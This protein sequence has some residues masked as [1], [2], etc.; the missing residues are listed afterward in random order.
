M[1]QLLKADVW[2]RPSIPRSLNR[3]VVILAVLE[4]FGDGLSRQGAL[5]DAIFIR[6]ELQNLLEFVIQVDL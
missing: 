5:A 2:P 1:N 4:I 6:I 3:N